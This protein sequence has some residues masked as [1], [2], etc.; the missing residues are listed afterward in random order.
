MSQVYR[1]L[2]ASILPLLISAF[3]FS[4][5]SAFDISS[6]E[7]LFS[8]SADQEEIPLSIRNLPF[9][10]DYFILRSNA[11][12]SNSRFREAGTG[13]VAFLGGSITH[14]PGWRDKVCAFLATRFPET[15]FEFINAG[16][17]SMGSTPGA[18]RI[19]RDVLSKGPVDL[20]FVDAAVN[21]STNGRSGEEQIRGMEGIV[22]QAWKDNPDTDI[23]FLY[24]AD[25]EKTRAYNQ[26]QVPD[27][28]RNHEKVAS[29]YGISSLNLALE[30][31]ERIRA[32]QFSWEKDFIDLHPS[33]FGQNLYAGSVARMLTQL[34]QTPSNKTEWL[35]PRALPAALLDD[36]S[37]VNGRLA[38][39]SEAK[40]QKGWKIVE[41]W[42]PDDGARTRDGF[43]SVPVLEATEPGAELDFHFHGKGAGIFVAAGPD[44]GS[45]EYSVDGGKVKSL[46][47]FTRWSPGLHLPW[48]YLLESELQPGPQGH[49]L[50]IKTS[51][52]RNTES[53]GHA[54]RIAHFLV[55]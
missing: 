32:G 2:K 47:L 48:A 38:D 12:S 50:N 37:Y 34:W 6:P 55:N 1:H 19:R 35:K 7:N 53:S 52:T 42:Q 40:I 28:I 51:G 44:A 16:I 4:H 33:P 31:A 39:I 15:E 29:Y 54:V 18:F 26:G 13:R 23:I 20:L 9:G 17:P 41:N 25:P 3:L 21:D 30:V 45:I 46:D 10:H 8:K 36:Y 49:T 14:N 43:V 22:R 5:V 24:F 27:V 11:D